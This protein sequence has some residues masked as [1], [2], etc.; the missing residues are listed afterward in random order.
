MGGVKRGGVYLDTHL[1]S[2]SSLD[3]IFVSLL[4]LN[5]IKGDRTCVL[6]V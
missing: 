4:S 3:A 5:N 2:V 1:V 6:E